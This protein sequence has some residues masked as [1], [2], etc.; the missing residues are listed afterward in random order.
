M[1]AIVDLYSQKEFLKKHKNHKS[2]T[3]YKTLRKNIYGELKS[4]HYDELYVPG[5]TKSN[6][7]A[8]LQK[9][10]NTEVN[11]GIHVFLTKERAE[12]DNAY[13]YKTIVPFKALIEDLI[14]VECNGR[15]VFRKVELSNKEYERAIK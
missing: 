14:C 10:D 8:K 2:V 1:C 15:A 13:G 12:I 3:V 9:R 11:R 5:I 4:I 7:K 6:S